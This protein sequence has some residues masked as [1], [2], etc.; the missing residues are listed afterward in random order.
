MGQEQLN[1]SEYYKE[2]RGNIDIV[3]LRK[4][5]E[6]L[7]DPC[8][9]SNYS[10]LSDYER[11]SQ[12]TKIT[13]APLCDQQLEENWY[14]AGFTDIPTEPPSMF[15]CGTTYPIWI[16][17]PTGEIGSASTSFSHIQWLNTRPRAG[18]FKRKPNLMF[19]CE[20]TPVH[21]SEMYYSINW[22]VDQKPV[23][24]DQTVSPNDPPLGYMSSEELKGFSA[25]RARVSNDDDD[26]V[27][28]FIG[29][30]R[31]LDDIL[32]IDNPVFEKY[33]NVIYPQELIRNKANVS[34]TET[35]FLDLNIKIVNGEIH[36]SV[37]DKRDD[38]GFNIVNFPWLDG[39]VP[40]LPSYG[41][42]IS[43]LIRYAR[44]CTDVL[45]FHSR[46]LQITKKL[47]GQGFRFHKLVKTFWK[48]YKNY[49]QLL[50]KFGP[51]QATEYITFGIS[52]P[53]FYG[54]I[55]NK[56]RRIKDKQHH[57]RKCVRIIKRLLYR[58]YDPNVTRRTL[59]L[60]LDQSTVL[61]KR[62]LKTCT[63][64]DCDDGTP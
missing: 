9:E 25:Q 62:I 51:I 3:T 61:Y 34:N 13:S 21:D 22:Y 59:G 64:T 16:N 38:F 47:L 8:S 35:P 29:T 56:I 26:Y 33:K 45:D 55:I 20:F 14:R 39:D 5:K 63:L 31:Y 52:Q 18:R 40:R 42:Y 23:I 53:A 60:V 50:L 36:T 2:E 17:A 58:G 41:I 10:P 32:T 15:S 37:Y 43:Q 12:G 57:Y 27:K 54:D 11:R 24:V 30:S 49:C 19:K 48:F 46:N 7:A 28:C 4:I 44:A 6:L 1:D